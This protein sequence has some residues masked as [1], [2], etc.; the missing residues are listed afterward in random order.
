M[1]TIKITFSLLLFTLF[2]YAQT[3]HTVDN[4]SQSG[5]MF[6]DLQM[7]VDAAVANDIIHIHPSATGYGSIIITKKLK[8]VGLGHDPI[9]H[10]EGLT[11]K[12]TGI[13][14]RGNSA[15]SEV[16][17]L[18]INSISVAT[19]S[20][21]LIDADNIHII[22]NKIT[23]TISTG[24]NAGKNDNWIIEGNYHTN[25]NSS[26]STNADGWVV[27]NNVIKCTINSF[28]VTN[29]VINNIFLYTGNGTS[30]TFFYSLDHTVVSNNIFIASSNL[31]SF[32]I[33]NSPFIDMRNNITYSFS[34]QTIA[35]LP[36]TN[37]LDNTNP[38]FTNVPV[39]TF[40]DFYNNDYSLQPASLG[41][42]YGTDG[43]DLGIFGSNFIFDTQGRPDLQPYP[44]DVIIN[45]NVIAPGQ[46]LSVRFTAAQKP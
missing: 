23:G 29:F 32:P 6:T 20:P 21:A 16:T 30:R 28:N 38:M 8:L 26:I 39:A 14:F 35:A 40:D 31:T 41:H 27:K 17:G 33:S 18:T 22:H 19:N 1:K 7:A 46:N 37:N 42:N 13:S 45:N 36:G 11:A 4:R 5:A 10:T 43:T 25:I 12:I 2:S 24:A 15:N 44:I 34:G 9:T 3:V